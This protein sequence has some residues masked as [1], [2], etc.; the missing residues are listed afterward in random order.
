MASTINVSSLTLNPK[1]V[2]NFGQII[3][4]MTFGKP[5]LRAMHRVF[6]GVTMK[7]Q[8]VLASQ[9]GLTGLKANG[10]T[11]QESDAQSTL[12]QKYWEPVGIEDTFVNCQAD[13]DGLFKAYFDKIKEY[14]QMYNIEASDE[15]AFIGNLVSEAMNETINRAIWFGDTNVTASTSSTAGLVDGNNAFGFD[16]FDGL[17]TQIFAGVGSNDIS[18]VDLSNFATPGS[19]T[20]AEA[21]GALMN[22]YKQADG[23]LRGN[24]DAKFY[25]SG[26]LFLALMEY[27]QANSVNFTLDYTMNGFPTMKFLGHDVINMEGIWD[28]NLQ[29]F[30]SD[31]TSHGAYLPDRIVF[32]IPDNIPVA[33]LNEDDMTTIESWYNID[34]RVNKT[35]YG[36]TLDAKVIDEKLITVAY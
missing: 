3:L 4:E 30:E 35:A 31:S 14:K 22:V 7:E 13:V 29:Y 23:R 19:P 9:L 34:E 2:Q 16:Y 27:M 25:V 20:A 12:T 10:C 15:E 21:Y 18:Y 33:T 17:W 11:R 8:I 32:T 24:T 26:Q 6:S 36:F 5:E 1:E 28:K